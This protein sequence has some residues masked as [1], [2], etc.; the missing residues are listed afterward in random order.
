[1]IKLGLFIFKGFVIKL[2]DLK[3]DILPINS[4]QA[5]KA[6]RVALVLLL[7]T[8]LLWNSEKKAMEK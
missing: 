8:A 5:Q 6:I 2:L 3:L 1:M 7:M 4:F